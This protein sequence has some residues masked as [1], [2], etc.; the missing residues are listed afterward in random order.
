MLPASRYSLLSTKVSRSA[1]GV[2]YLSKTVICKTPDGKL[3]VSKCPTMDGYSSN[4]ISTSYT[5]FLF[6]CATTVMESNFVLSAVP[7]LNV[8]FFPPG[9][10]CTF[11]LMP[12]AWTAGNGNFFIPLVVSTSAK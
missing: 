11:K 6:N 7:L 9:S 1:M 12:E 4:A 8:N 2:P 5:T 10:S 3:S